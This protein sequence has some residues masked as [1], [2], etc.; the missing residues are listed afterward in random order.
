MNK[1]LSRLREIMEEKGISVRELSE[2][3]GVSKSTMQR[4]LSGKSC[5]RAGEIC[6]ISRVLHIDNIKEIFFE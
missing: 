2:K 1:G 6:S 3:I 5:F 4:R